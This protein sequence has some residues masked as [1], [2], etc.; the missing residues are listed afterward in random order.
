MKKRKILLIY[1]NLGFGG[2][3]KHIIELYKYFSLHNTVHIMAKGG[4]LVNN[5]KKEHFI[6]IPKEFSLYSL[7]YWKFVLSH[8]FKYNYDLI[9]V[10]HRGQIFILNLISMINKKVRVIATCHNVFPN[11]NKLMLWPKNVIAVSKAAKTIVNSSFFSKLRKPYVKVI[12]NGID[13]DQTKKYIAQRVSLEQRGLPLLL[14]FV[15]RLEKQKNPLEII[16]IMRL[17]VRYNPEFNL[18]ILGDGSLKE[19]LIQKAY[20]YGLQNKIKIIGFVDNVFPYLVRA[21][22]HIVTSLWEGL[23]ISTLE[24]MCLGIPTIAYEI[25][26][27]KEVIINGVNG[28]LVKD[29]AEF[30]EKISTLA[31]DKKLYQKL[32]KNALRIAY[33]NF[34]LHTMLKKTE[35]FYNA[36]LNYESLD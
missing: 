10:H 30:I 31:K 12:Y 3:Q 2:V 8:L 9:H 13:L 20:E 6:E 26:T 21:Y 29:R 25:P 11:R 4:E 23:P 28:F 1:T 18:Y 27:L 17:L 35:E 33:T 22:V 34:N 7:K 5:I 15:G 24:A 19:I 16:E 32:C 14:L 36:V